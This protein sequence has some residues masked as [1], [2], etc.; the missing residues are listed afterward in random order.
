MKREEANRLR[1][2]HSTATHLRVT[3][4][5]CHPNR[6]NDSNAT[7]RVDLKPDNTVNSISAICNIYKKSMWCYGV[8]GA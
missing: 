8:A 4:P 2:D 7:Q 1:F 6:Q 5:D 3:F